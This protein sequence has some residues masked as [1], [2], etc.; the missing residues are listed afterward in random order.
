MVDGD[1]AF[2]WSKPQ[3]NIVKITMDVAILT[4]DMIL[5]SDWLLGMR[6][7]FN[8]AKSNLYQWKVVLKL[9]E[10]ISM[11]KILSWI[12][13]MDWPGWSLNLIA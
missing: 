7:W 6:M 1:G 9:A 11:K 10:A 2:A 13:H 5:V 8:Q 3:Q 4:I 12:M